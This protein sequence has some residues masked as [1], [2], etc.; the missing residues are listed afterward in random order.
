MQPHESPSVSQKEPCGPPG[1]PRGAESE[2]ALLLLPA[3]YIFAACL[4]PA[5]VRS[6]LRLV[7][8]G[9]LKDI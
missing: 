1:Q 4:I 3:R 5:E 9:H 8:R 2:G 7:K 6:Q